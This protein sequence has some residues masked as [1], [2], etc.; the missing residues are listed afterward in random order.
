LGG[1]LA[2]NNDD[3]VSGSQAAQLLVGD[4]T[5]TPFDPVPIHRFAQLASDDKT[6]PIVVTPVGQ[7]AEHHQP[8]APRFSIAPDALKISRAAQAQAAWQ[9]GSKRS[10]SPS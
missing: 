7:H 5:Q 4:G 1:G 8:I 10:N 2:G 9:H 6:K 3:I